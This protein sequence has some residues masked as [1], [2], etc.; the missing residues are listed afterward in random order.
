MVLQLIK[1]P[2]L[3]HYILCTHKMDVVVWDLAIYKG[4][5]QIEIRLSWTYSSDTMYGGY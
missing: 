1:K 5:T 4:L 3:N 2:S